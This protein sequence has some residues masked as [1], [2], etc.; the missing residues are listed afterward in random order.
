MS[1]AR[2]SM[3]ASTR[4]AFGRCSTTI[5]GLEKRCCSP[6]R[7]TWG[8][9]GQRHRE[10][11]RERGREREREREGGRE[12]V[13]TKITCFASPT[14]PSHLV[15]TV[16]LL[17]ISGVNT[18]WSPESFIGA[19]PPPGS[20]GGQRSPA[21]IRICPGLTPRCLGHRDREGDQRDG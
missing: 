4:C 20:Q 7:A 5:S 10:A 3:S 1:P 6:S 11:E 13:P 19:R 15:V 21:G 16:S 2:C 9:E 14:P 17:Q 18:K 12:V 8:S